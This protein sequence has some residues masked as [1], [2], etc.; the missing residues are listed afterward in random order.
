MWFGKNEEEGTT[1]LAIHFARMASGSD[2]GRRRRTSS[3]G[4]TQ[5]GGPTVVD[6]PWE[7]VQDDRRGLAMLVDGLGKLEKR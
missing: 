7:G 3:L 1:F 4:R 6:S 5:R 2:L